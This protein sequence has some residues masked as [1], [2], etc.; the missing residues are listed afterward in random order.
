MDLRQ[1]LS[2]TIICFSVMGV[3]AGHAQDDPSKTTFSQDGDARKGKLVFLQCRA[4]HNLTASG[5]GRAGPHLAGLIGRTVGGDTSYTRYS[6]VLKTAQFKW[7]EDRINT[8]LTNPN[9]F[10]PGLQATMRVR[11]VRKEQ[12]RKDLLA[13]LRQ[14]TG[15]TK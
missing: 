6:D 15:R 3:S 5:P 14:A 7:T 11:K 12:D 1:I 10:L 4:C 9:G 2:A 8:F 13:F